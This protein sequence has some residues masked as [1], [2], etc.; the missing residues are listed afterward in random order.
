MNSNT[1]SVLLKLSAAIGLLAGIGVFASGVMQAPVGSSA[2]QPELTETQQAMQKANQAMQAQDWSAA[3]AGFEGV[4]KR[5][6]NSAVAKFRLAYCV[7][8]SGDMDRAIPLHEAAAEHPQQRPVALYNLG[9]AHALKGNTD[10]AFEAL[11]GSVDAGFNGGA[12]GLVSAHADTDLVSLRDDPRFAELFGPAP[13]DDKTLLRFWL[14]EWDC[15]SASSGSKSGTN[16]FTLRNGDRVIL[17]EWVASDNS[18]GSSWN[19]FDT[20]TGKWMQAWVDGGGGSTL[21]AGKRQGSGILFEGKNAPPKAQGDSKKSAYPTL[22]RM[23]VRPI[24]G[25]RVQQ[26]GTASTDNGKTWQPRYDLIYVP[27]GQPFALAKP[28]YKSD[29]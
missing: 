4:L 19:W 6:P 17:E 2:S 25:G 7:H 13:V 27:K 5:D 16:T 3:I 18:F 23:F 26:T 15:Y 22:H 1:N 29:I 10:K 14:G 9:C 12:G 8:A 28:G 21:F 24:D 20:N 11:T